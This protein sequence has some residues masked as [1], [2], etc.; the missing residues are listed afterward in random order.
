MPPRTFYAESGPYHFTDK[1]SEAAVEA[2][3]PK[4]RAEGFMA[5]TIICFIKVYT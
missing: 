5:D 2:P 4:G 3:G 1:M